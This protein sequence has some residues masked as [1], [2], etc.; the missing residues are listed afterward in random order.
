MK[1]SFYGYVF[2]IALVI[3][4]Y[5]FFRPGYKQ[6]R[7]GIDSKN[8]PVAEGIVTESELTQHTDVDNDVVYVFN[9]VY[10]YMVMG[11]MFKN[12]Q[13]APRRVDSYDAADLSEY[14]QNYPKGSAVTVHY[15]PVDPG[16]S[17]IMPGTRAWS[18]I[19]LGLAS[20]V[21]LFVLAIVSGM[22]RQRYGKK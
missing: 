7:L 12:S 20:L 2:L 21:W 22:I 16:D 11:R 6:L 14:L 3:L 1:E 19:L 4:G 8:W 13:F 9:I 18:W 5:L 10:E 15:N 17:I